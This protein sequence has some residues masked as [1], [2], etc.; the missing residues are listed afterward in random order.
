MKRMMTVLMMAVLVLTGCGNSAERDEQAFIKWAKDGGLSDMLINMPEENVLVLGY[1]TCDMKDYE[2]IDY[3]KMVLGISMSEYE[4]FEFIRSA[5]RWLC[6]NPNRKDV[7][8]SK[9]L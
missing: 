7:D 2:G 8:Y 3:A 4:T 9:Y 6:D 5:D 1:A